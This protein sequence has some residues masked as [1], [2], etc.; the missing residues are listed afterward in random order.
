MNVTISG[1]S[2]ATWRMWKAARS[3]YEVI[4]EETGE[5]RKVAGNHC[6]NGGKYGRARIQKRKK[7]WCW[8][9]PNKGE[10]V[11]YFFKF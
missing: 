9:D 7:P 3:S 1:A 2:C 5:K 8:V 4:D 11:S 10:W 6:R